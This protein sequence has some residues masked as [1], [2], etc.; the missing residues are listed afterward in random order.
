MRSSN[1][2]SLKFFRSSWVSFS[3]H[4][5]VQP[6]LSRGLSSPYAAN[7]VSLNALYGGAT[8]H[9]C[10]LCSRFSPL[11]L[12]CRTLWNHVISTDWSMNDHANQ[13]TC[14]AIV[15]VRPHSQD[16]HRTASHVPLSSG[17]TR[18]WRPDLNW[19]VSSC[20]GFA[21]VLTRQPRVHIPAF[22]R[23]YAMTGRG[24]IFAFAA[25]SRTALV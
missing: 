19:S 6:W 9:G 4:T 5:T 1:F 16:L 8:S 23:L 2:R 15:G 7:N 24:N 20:V 17:L 13:W 3:L 10:L 21:P 11:L 22:D 18:K 25:F 12:P 14:T